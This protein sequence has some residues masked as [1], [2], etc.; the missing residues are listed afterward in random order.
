MTTL[1]W[2][3]D[4]PMTSLPHPRLGLCTVYAA[5][6]VCA[7]VCVYMCVLTIAFYSLS[8]SGWTMHCSCMFIIGASIFLHAN[9]TILTSASTSFSFLVFFCFVC[10]FFILKRLRW[11]LC[12]S[13]WNS[14]QSHKVL[15]VI[16]CSDLTSV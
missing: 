14:G 16:L 8:S 11:N 9:C 10:S 7:C 15:Y 3:G 1:G 13:R 5:Y 2:R 4:S 6:T 12:Q